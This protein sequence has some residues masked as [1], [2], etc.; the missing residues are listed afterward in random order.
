M[1]R[2]APPERAAQVAVVRWL[3]LELPAGAQIAAVINE[4]RAASSDPH[5][6]A[7][8]YA[9]KIAA[10]LNP[11]WP[12][13]TIA[14][15]GGRTLYV[16]IKRPDGGILSQQQQHVHAA[17]RALGH[18]V[19]VCTS[20]EDVRGFLQSQGVELREAAD[21]PVSEARYRVA[22]AHASDRPSKAAAQVSRAEAIRKKVM[23]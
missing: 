16:E 2:P 6:R 12:D 17:L 1:V 20:I 15:H 4:S 18:P 9:A 10:G 22:K 11:G 3:R 13:L 14:L 7:R 19:G 5:A 21:Q 8:Y 23:F